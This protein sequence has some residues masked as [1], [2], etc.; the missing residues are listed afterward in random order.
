MRKIITV[1]HT[2][3]EQHING[4]IGS[5]CDWDLTNAGIKQA[6]LIG[7]YLVEATKNGDYTMYSSDLLRAKHT[8]EIISQHIGIYPIFTDELREFNLGEAI[9]KTKEWARNN[10]R[11]TTWDGTIDW[12]LDV[13]AKP[14]YDSESKKD[15]WERLS[16]FIVRAMEQSK[17]MIIVSHDGTLSVLYAL[18]IG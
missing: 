10:V 1:Q 18:W 8:A 12:P 4:M 5:W 3:S 14:F 7:E 13:Y 2:Q 15:V 16:K 9:G 17:D 6:H 11:C